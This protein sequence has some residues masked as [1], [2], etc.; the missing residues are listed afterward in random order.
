MLIHFSGM[1][2]WS[3]VAETLKQSVSLSRP[4][5]EN[6]LSIPIPI[7]PRIYDS[8]THLNSY[9]PV[10]CLQPVNTV[11][12]M[13]SAA[14]SNCNSE[15][16]F[17]IVFLVLSFFFRFFCIMFI[18][19]NFFWPQSTLNCPNKEQELFVLQRN[20]LFLVPFQQIIMKQ[21]K[22]VCQNLFVFIKL[23][24]FM[25]EQQSNE[26]QLLSKSFKKMLPAV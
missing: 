11:Y 18:R 9:T 25:A 12:L 3:Q 2:L 8:L 22:I 19:T 21:A 13:N 5:Q 10:S 15:N 7:H 14:F 26:F 1:I 24:I 4:I 23:F 6:L 16:Y 17:Q 20:V